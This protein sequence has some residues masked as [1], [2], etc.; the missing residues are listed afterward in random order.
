[1]KKYIFIIIGMI[2]SILGFEL[3][4]TDASDKV[5]MTVLDISQSNITIE[6]DSI[7]AYDSDGNHIT[8]VNSEGY[9]IM[10]SQ[11]RTGNY[12]VVGENVSTKIVLDNVTIKVNAN[13]RNSAFLIKP[14][15][16]VELVLKNNNS[17]TGG[18]YQ[19]G[20]QVPNGNSGTPAEL[21]ITGDGSLTAYAEHRAAAIG[22]SED[23][24]GADAGII[25]I[26]SGTISAE[27]GN[28]PGGY[29]AA[30]GG[31][32]SGSC[33]T[34]IIDGGNIKAVARRRANAIGGGNNATNKGTIIINGGIINAYCSYGAGSYG[35][36]YGLGAS[37]IQ[38]NG[39]YVLSTTPNN[40]YASL[41]KEAVNSNGETV[42][43]VGIDFPFTNRNKTAS[44]MTS[45]GPFEVQ[46]D[47]E[48]RA[49][50][51]IPETTLLGDVKISNGNKYVLSETNVNGHIAN[52]L[53]PSLPTG[54]TV[55]DVEPEE[56]TS[57]Y[58]NP[59]NLTYTVKN[60]DNQN[61][62]GVRFDGKLEIDNRDVGEYEISGDSLVIH[63]DI[64]NFNFIFNKKHQVTKR[65]LSVYMDPITI[66]YG[67]EIPLNPQFDNFAYDD[68]EQDL[69]G[70]ISYVLDKSVMKPNVYTMTFSGYQSTNYD[71]QYKEN[72]LT[73]ISATDGTYNY[74]E[75]IEIGKNNQD[76]PIKWKVVKVT[77]KQTYLINES[78]I[79]KSP[80]GTNQAENISASLTNIQFNDYEKTYIDSLKPVTQADLSNYF[81]TNNEYIV[82]DE[83]HQAMTWWLSDSEYDDINLEN[84]GL[85][86]DEFGHIQVGQ[87]SDE[88]GVRGVMIINRTHGIA[89]VKIQPLSSDFYNFIEKSKEVAQVHLFG[90][91]E[92][93][94]LYLVDENNKTSELFEIDDLGMIKTK[95]QL[96]IGRYKIKIIAKDDFGKT[97]FDTYQFEIKKKVD[98]D[99]DENHTHQ[100][101]DIGNSEINDE[102]NNNQNEIPIQ[103][104]ITI[105]PHQ[106]QEVENKE[107]HSSYIETNDNT[108]L[109]IFIS[110]CIISISSAVFI[111]ISH[112]NNIF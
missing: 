67:Q 109:Y 31:S 29:G 45:S 66:T 55:L 72:S 35:T 26:K 51:Y 53:I 61:I 63:S 48:A 56:N 110:L 19:S 106:N 81:E 32:S 91:Y 11:T 64:Y 104:E 23:S 57:T 97:V 60:K 76:E 89:G 107:S 100:K 14:S 13:T 15:A 96:D 38:I 83:N 36:Y 12:I 78:I 90:Q 86:V 27:T 103:E 6:N 39:G 44:I 24:Y 16:K 50:F 105:I 59:L 28:N 4:Q 58:G 82:Y 80:W 2:F 40:G 10:S 98:V 34:I 79:E 99:I 92:S 42:Y 112:E 68:T 93:C 101:P 9:Y 8:D 95:K 21:I 37:S 47:D 5:G 70:E 111:K 62:Q 88:R 49:R 74:G 75:V 41:S 65:K 102:V 17:L 71:I 7:D 3:L 20:I 22:G 43:F 69:L 30:I 73:I 84:N 77:D 85:Y 18:K 54:V 94:D 52:I 87:N 46:L 33:G 25:T 1:M 108:N